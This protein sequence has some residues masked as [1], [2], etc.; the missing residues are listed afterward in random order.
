MLKD[1]MQA[2]RIS[3]SKVISINFGITFAFRNLESAG[4]VNSAQA[5]TATL[6]KDWRNIES[7]DFRA[8]KGLSSLLSSGRAQKEKLEQKGR[9]GRE[10]FQKYYKQGEPR[11]SDH[12]TGLMEI[13][14]I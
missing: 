3:I 12:E 7:V 14:Q 9:E 2:L 6:H 10:A 11:K 1:Q 13:C 5:A 4:E 8:Q